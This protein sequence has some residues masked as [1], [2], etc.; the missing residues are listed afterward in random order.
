MV[1]LITGAKPRLAGAG[2]ALAAGAALGFAL[3]G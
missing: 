3:A 2:L 1:D